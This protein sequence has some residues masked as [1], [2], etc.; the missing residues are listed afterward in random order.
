MA[1]L[2]VLLE[3][4]AQAIPENGYLRARLKGILE[5]VSSRGS[6]T[7]SGNAPLLARWAGLAAPLLLQAR[8]VRRGRI[9]PGRGCAL[10]PDAELPVSLHGAATCPSAGRERGTS[11]PRRSR[12]PPSRRPGANVRAPEGGVRPAASPT[13]SP[14]AMRRTAEVERAGPPFGSR[15]GSA[16]EPRCRTG[17]SRRRGDH[18][19]VTRLGGWYVGH[20]A[21]VDAARRAARGSAG[22]ALVDAIKRLLAAVDSARDEE[23]RR[24]A[25]RIAAWDR[26]A[27]A[28]V[29]IEAALDR[30]AVPFLEKYAQ[31]RLV[32]VL[33]DGMSWAVALELLEDL[34]N[35]EPDPYAVSRG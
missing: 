17:R 27:G 23:D 8:A 6:A 13:G 22:D 2:A 4:C 29:P 33:L 12:R 9:A 25:P 10:L 21:Y 31:R 7:P 28:V 24:F 26:R 20:G 30:I 19:V 3:A 34:A 16:G 11:S 5:R 32:V 35:F 18:E 14:S 1:A 15:P